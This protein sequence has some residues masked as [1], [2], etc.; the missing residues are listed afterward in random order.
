LTVAAADL[1]KAEAVGAFSP[2]RGAGSSPLVLSLMQHQH[3]QLTMSLPLLT[4]HQQPA[5]PGACPLDP[6]AGACSTGGGSLGGSMGS[7]LSLQH[8]G[9]SGLAIGS[10]EGQGL[11][12]LSAAGS[13]VRCVNCAAA[14]SITSKSG[15]ALKWHPS[16]D[17]GTQYVAC[18]DVCQL[19]T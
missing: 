6:A 18:Y 1:G 8:V 10:D 14:A 3:Q 5:V 17:P 9:S 16:A 2:A 19:H 4:S 12:I 15:H 7:G 11:V 13:D